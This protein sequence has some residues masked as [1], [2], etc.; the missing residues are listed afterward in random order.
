MARPTKWFSK[1]SREA[2]EKLYLLHSR[3]APGLGPQS[4]HSKKQLVSCSGNV[5]KT[6]RCFA[7][8]LLFALTDLVKVEPALLDVLEVVTDEIDDVYDPLLL[9][10][11]ARRLR[12]LS[13]KM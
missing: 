11:E 3:R 7:E 13:S 12:R 1:L 4:L 10:I 2:K 5:S 8:S 9:E 6:L